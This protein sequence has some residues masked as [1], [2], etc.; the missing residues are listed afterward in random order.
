MRWRGR[1]TASVRSAQAFGQYATHFLFDRTLH[2][3]EQQAEFRADVKFAG[4]QRDA[5]VDTAA[6]EMQHIALPAIVQ[7]ETL[8]EL[9]R[10]ILDRLP[11][12]RRLH[13]MR[14]ADI[15]RGHARMPCL[16]DGMG[17]VRRPGATSKLRRVVRLL[18]DCRP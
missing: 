17:I 15:D 11:G 3:G 8:A 2:R 6:L 18:L 7:A 9:D 4:E 14:M 5:T 12:L 10:K 1:E 13:G 16:C